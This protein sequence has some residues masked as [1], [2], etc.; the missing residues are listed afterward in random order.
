MSLKSIQLKTT[1]VTIFFFIFCFVLSAEPLRTEAESYFYSIQWGDL[2]G[3]EVQPLPQPFRPDNQGKPIPY[4][5]GTEESDIYPALKPLG[6]LNY[7][8][9][10]EELLQ[11]Y[12]TIALS[13]KKKD[14]DA[15][16]CNPDKPFLPHLTHFIFEQF[17]Q[18]ETVFY[19]RPDFDAEGKATTHFKLTRRTD[20]QAPVL[21]KEKTEEQKASDTKDK[22]KQESNAKE[23]NS[24]GKKT[25]P[26]K[27]SHNQNKQN[28]TS[29]TEN[30]P[31]DPLPTIYKTAQIIICEVAAV[32]KDGT[33]YLDHIDI[34]GAE[35]ADSAHTN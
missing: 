29:S 22:L 8:S 16:L 28:E 17:P 14:I 3:L 5:G 34:K 11:F 31:K 21:T 27:N 1:A 19:S 35:Y 32:Q 10:S 12:D 6:T 15:K 7:Q 25:E 23:G 18:S 24:V 4:A 26:N 33:W 20:N 9:I 2:S 30:T 13:M